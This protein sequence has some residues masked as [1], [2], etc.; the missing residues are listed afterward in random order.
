MPPLLSRCPTHQRAALALWVPKVV[1]RFAVIFSGADIV[2]RFG[3]Q[4]NPC[5]FCNK[6]KAVLDYSGIPWQAVEVDPLFKAE[7]KQ[8][9]LKKVR[10]TFLT[11]PTGC[12]H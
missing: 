9:G 1:L 5:P 4:Y 6:V 7:M 8:T 2:A 12:S 3:S 10:S 11:H